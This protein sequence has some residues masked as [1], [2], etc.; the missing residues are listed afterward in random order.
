MSVKRVAIQGS[1]SGQA[2]V[3]SLLAIGFLMAVI[4]A[5]SVTMVAYSRIQQHEHNRLASLYLARSGIEKG[6]MFIAED[7]P[8][9]DSLF[10][11][12]STL[13]GTGEGELATGF[14]GF[15]TADDNGREEPGIVDEERKLNINTASAGMLAAFIPGSVAS[16]VVERRAERPFVT[17]T[18]FLDYIGDR[19]NALENAAGKA[20]L[21]S[22]LT[23]YG[24]GRINVNTAS[25]AV[26]RCIE[27]LSPQAADILL[28]RRTAPADEEPDVPFRTLDE[29]RDVLQLEE[30]SWQLIEPWIDVRS[31]HFTLRSWGR[32]RS[33]PAAVTELRVTV[34]RDDE[35]LRIIQWSQDTE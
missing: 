6:L 32:S 10:D 12:W 24:S 14:F 9:S 1:R 25:E 23:V 35:S 13:R 28:D 19:G 5:V 31:T 16:D 7:D 11:S 3:L 2:I 27:G 26:L 22:H 4:G 17:V 30:E 15:G 33:R 8:S 21:K 29:V 18:E 20:E 34:K